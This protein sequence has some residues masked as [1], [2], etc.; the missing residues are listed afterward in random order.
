MQAEANAHK[1]YK[2]NLRRPAALNNTAIHSETE[3]LHE[4]QIMLFLLYIHG[5]LRAYNDIFPTLC[6]NYTHKQ[7]TAFGSIFFITLS[8]S[9]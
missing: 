5:A 7:L 6:S 3:P 9:N 8:G 1:N 4:L 2:P